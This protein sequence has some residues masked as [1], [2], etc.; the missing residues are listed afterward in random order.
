MI[1]LVLIRKLTNTHTQ[2]HNQ[3]N[4]AHTYESSTRRGQ[5][6]IYINISKQTNNTQNAAILIHSIQKDKVKEMD[7][8]HELGITYIK[9]SQHKPSVYLIEF[10]SQHTLNYIG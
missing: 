7:I 6:Y 1:T 2:H 4:Q 3:S 9:S 5:Q 10:P 8:R